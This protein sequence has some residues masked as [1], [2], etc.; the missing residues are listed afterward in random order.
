MFERTLTIA[1]CLVLSGGLVSGQTVSMPMGL[2][3][4]FMRIRTITNRSQSAGQVGA[5]RAL[6]FNLRQRKRC[7]RG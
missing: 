1:F 5:S 2:P 3:W 7:G 4:L 6:L